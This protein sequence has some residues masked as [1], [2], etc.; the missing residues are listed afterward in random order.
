MK[1]PFCT[2]L[3][4]DSIQ[5][6][7]KERMWAQLRFENG[8][9]SGDLNFFEYDNTYERNRDGKLVITG[10][11]KKPKQLRLRIIQK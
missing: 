11:T 5:D 2:P 8:E 1:Y 3:V 9:W 10:Y 6:C 4:I 7:K